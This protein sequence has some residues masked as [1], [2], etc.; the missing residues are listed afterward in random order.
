MNLIKQETTLK[1]KDVWSGKVGFVMAFVWCVLSV[2]PRSAR[3]VVIQSPAISNLE[4]EGVK[5]AMNESSWVEHWQRNLEP[6]FTQVEELRERVEDAQ[7]EWLRKSN[8]STVEKARAI[9]WTAADKLWILLTSQHWPHKFTKDLAPA[10]LRIAQWMENSTA[11]PSQISIWSL[12]ADLLQSESTLRSQPM[13][14]SN[15]A[16][17]L[18]VTI[19]AA[20]IKEWKDN[21]DEVWINGSRVLPAVDENSLKD[22]NIANDRVWVDFVS[23]RF[24]NYSSQISTR[25]LTT[26]SPERRPWVSGDCQNGQSSGLNLSMTEMPVEFKR[27]YETGS[28]TMIGA[29]LCLMPLAPRRSTEIQS[30]PKDVKSKEAKS[31]QD[32]GIQYSGPPVENQ[33]VQPSYRGLW[34][35]LAI[36]VV[37]IGVYSAIRS[38]DQRPA[39][40]HSEGF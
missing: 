9:D 22:I 35:G 20:K 24:Q 37:A 40:T 34:I 25:S 26:L 27:L 31:I 2:L 5:Q 18:F 10:F 21:W 8:S 33:N 15:Q 1:T 16:S 7:R 36:G 4:F 23:N 3:A 11:D 30:R 19:P 13:P 17:N 6:T 12:R 29:N 14:L 32:F 39:A 38:Q 28:I